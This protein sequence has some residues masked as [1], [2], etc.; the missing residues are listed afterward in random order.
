M[1][2]PEL[3]AK[4]ARLLESSGI[5]YMITGSHASSAMGQPRSTHDIDFVVQMREEDLS[6][7]AGAFAD[8]RFGFDEVAAREAILRNDMFQ[9][10]DFSGGDKVD[11]WMLKN[12]AFD[13]ESFRRRIRGT[14]AGVSVYLP[15]I[16]DH[17]IQKI[18]W[19]HEYK[20][21][22]QYNDALLLYELHAAKLNMPYILKW[23]SELH[24]KSTWDRMVAEA[25]PL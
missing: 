18:R 23:V 22:R 1:S 5:P 10:Q 8:E 14:A 11:F 15:T 24:L 6:Q 20:S 17:I 12:Q 19:A 2:Q 7:F 3:L 9:L 21:D 4:V 16:E 13:Q 25:E